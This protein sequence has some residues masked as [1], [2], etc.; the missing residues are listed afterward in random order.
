VIATQP[1]IEEEDQYGNLET[2]DNSTVV[3]AS[4]SSG[5]ADDKVDGDATL[6]GL[7]LNK[8]GGYGLTI[9]GDGPGVNAVFTVLPKARNVV[10]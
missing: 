4:L 7:T 2:S 3:T 1:V 5:L 8:A 9:S 10:G 6:T